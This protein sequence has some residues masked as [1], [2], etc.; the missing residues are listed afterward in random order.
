M[1]QERGGVQQS[2][3]VLTWVLADGMGAQVVK[4][5]FDVRHTSV[6]VTGCKEEEMYAFLGRTVDLV[7]R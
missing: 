3:L 7:D 5:A 1:R 6:I 2:S 4:Q